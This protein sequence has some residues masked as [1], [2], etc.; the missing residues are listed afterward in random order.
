MKVG[1]MQPYFFPYIGYWQLLN[2]VDTYVI[3]DDVNYIKKGWINRNRILVNGK[4]QYFNLSLSKAS[5]NKKINEL[6]IAMGKEEKKKFLKTVHL[7]YSKAPCFEQVYVLLEEVLND[8]ECN[9]AKFLENSIHKIAAFLEIKTHIINSSAIE[10]DNAL[11]GQEK[12]IAINRKLGSTHYINAVGGKELYTQERFEKE[13]IRLNF[14]ETNEIVYQQFNHEFIPN[15]SIID[16][17]M[18]NDKENIKKMLGE[19]QLI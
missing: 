11:K 16:V 10:K 1:I 3:Y 4:P 2:L 7:N 6:E 12:I 9:L 14:L 19:Y 15:L 17:M 18:F 13:K 5:Q 8:E